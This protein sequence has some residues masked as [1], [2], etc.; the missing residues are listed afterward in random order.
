M[1]E[2]LLKKSS[3]FLTAFILPQLS[4][5]YKKNLP[6]LFPSR[7][8]LLLLLA[9]PLHSPVG[10]T[11]IIVFGFYTKSICPYGYANTDPGKYGTF[12]SSFLPLKFSSTFFKRWQ[13]IQKGSA[14]LAALRRERKL[15]YVENAGRGEKTAR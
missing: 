5:H 8:G 12:C 3:G 9:A 1:S 7:L 14:L 6:P 13:E 15:L 10:C 11:K 4:F 2:R